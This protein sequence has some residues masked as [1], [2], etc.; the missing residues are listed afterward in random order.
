MKQIQVLISSMYYYTHKKMKKR[1]KG[2]SCPPTKI[3]KRKPPRYYKSLT[4]PVLVGLRRRSPTRISNG[5]RAL[6]LVS[7]YK[8]LRVTWSA[9]S[10]SL[11]PLH[12]P[13]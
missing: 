7:A 1:K 8:R 2:N 11:S 13:A 9:R 12:M 5:K 6:I 4:L 3:K 10:I